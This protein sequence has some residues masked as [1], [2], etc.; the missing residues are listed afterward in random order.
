MSEKEIQ[1]KSIEELKFPKNKSDHLGEGSYA[2]VKLCLHTTS[3]RWFAL[4][5]INLKKNVHR[6]S[7]KKR[8]P[9]P[10]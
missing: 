8:V 2:K 1:V 3:N 7:D 5:I 4:K 6:F 9:I 10:F